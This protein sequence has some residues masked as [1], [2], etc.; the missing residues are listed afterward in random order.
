[1]AIIKLSAAERKKI[2]I[3]FVCILLAVVAWFFYALSNKYDY[4]LKTQVTFKN[5]PDNKAFYPLQSDTVII[6]VQGTG[7]QLL[8]NKLKLIKREIQ[9]DLKI[10]NKRNYVT[11]SNQ[12]KSINANFS[13]N[14]VI[15][16]VSPDTLF[17][18]FTTRRVKRVPVKFISKI[19]F[20]KQFGQSAKAEI[21]PAYIT[22]TGPIEQLKKIDQWPTDTFKKVEIANTIN[23]RV[24]LQKPKEAN[25]TIFPTAVEVNFPVDE[26]TEKVLQIPIKII[27]NAEYYN[28]RLI[29]EKVKLT[30]MVSLDNFAQ[31]TEDDYEA[32]V[33]LNLWK[34]TG[35]YQLPVKVVKKKL[36][37]H[38]RNV[39]PQQVDFIIKK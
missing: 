5:L 16:S 12:L 7:W 25:I 32:F 3:F 27:N 6:N 11:F 19:D 34:N 17:F 21:K 37:N 31:I 1:M 30:V 29:P 26:F 10:L 24:N 18:D 28:I 20:K 22:I 23:A 9:V 39:N 33:D 14:Q 2:S 38:I 36:F 15:T 13:S 35:T 4:Q 8:F